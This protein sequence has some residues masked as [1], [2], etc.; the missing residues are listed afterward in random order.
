MK[1]SI[2]AFQ[3]RN[4]TCV[5]RSEMR[6]ILS[7]VGCTLSDLE[8]RALEK[9]IKGPATKDA[10]FAAICRELEGIRKDWVLTLFSNLETIPGRAPK[11][12]VV[13]AFSPEKHPDV[14]AAR[15][16]SEEIRRRFVSAFDMILD[17]KQVDIGQDS[18][19]E[20]FRY[21]SAC[22]DK[23]EYFKLILEN[24]WKV[25]PKQS[26][27][28]K[29]LAPPVIS[30]EKRSPTKP[31]CGTLREALKLGQQLDAAKSHIY[32]SKK[33]VKKAPIFD[34]SLPAGKLTKIRS[35]DGASACLNFQQPTSGSSSRKIAAREA[36]AGIQAIINRLKES[37]SK[38]GVHGII[39]LSRTFKR[40]DEDGSGALNMSEFT[41]AM[42]DADLR[43]TNT[44]IRMLFDYF[45]TNHSG[46]L[47]LEEF[48]NGV[49]EPMTPRR[50]ALVRQA[51]S[52][53]DKD[54][55]GLLEPSDIVE[56]YDASQHPDVLS[57]SKTPDQIFRDFLD[58]FDVD[59]LH[60][61]KITPEEWEHYYNNISG[62]IQD[63]DYFELMMRNAWHISGGEGWCE[64]STNRR[65]LVTHMDGRET[66]EEIKADLHMSPSDMPAI[67]N[68]L[69]LQGIRA[70][71]IKLH[72]AVDTTK[73][74]K[75]KPR[76][77]RES[78][79]A[80][81]CLDHT[82]RLRS[83]NR[84][85]ETKQAASAG[86]QA[87][88]EKL[89]QMLKSRGAHGIIGLARAF[90]LMDDDGNRVLSLGE[91]IKAIRE[92]KLELSDREI[93]LLFEH[94]DTDHNGSIDF[95]EFLAGVRDPMNER[96]LELV[97]RAFRLIDKDNNGLLEPSD[98]VE[99]YDAS[100]HPEVLAGKKSPEQ[101]FREFLDTFDVDHLHTGAITPEEWEHYYQN[102]SSSIDDDD[103]FELMMRNAW[104]ISGGTGWCANTS[105]RRV[106]VT[107]LDGRETV[108]EIKDDIHMT[109][110]DV[111]AIVNHLR[112]Q[113][114]EAK[115]VKLTSAVEENPPKESA[116]ACLSMID[117]APLLRNPRRQQ[118]RA[119]NAG[120]QAILNRLK[121]ELKS[122]GCRG[123]IGLGRTF[124]IMD[125]DGN[126]S[127]SLGEFTRA[128]RHDGLELNDREIRLLFEYFDVDHSRS[129]D[130]N[131]FLVGVRDP[132]NARRLELVRKAFQLMDKDNNGLLE[133]SDIV[134]TY[135]S[136]QHPEVLSGA[137]T[138]EQVFREF[139]D[140][141]DVDGLH[142][143]K[144]TP[145][146]WEH[147][148]ANVSSSIDDDDYFELMMRNAWRISGGTGWCENTANRRVLVT[149]KDGRETIE[150]IKDDLNVKSSDMSAITNHLRLQGV[151]ARE[152][153]LLGSV[154][155]TPARRPTTKRDAF[156]SRGTASCLRQDDNTPQST[157]PR[158]KTKKKANAG[159]QALLNR[160]KQL[161]KARGVHG[162]IGLAR[163]FRMMDEDRNGA[164]N[165]AEFRHA[166]A[167]SQ[168]ELSGRDIQMLF[169]YFDVDH[170]GSIE[171][172]EFLAGVRDPMNPKRLELVRQAFR[173]MDKDNNGL[174][175]PKDIVQ[176]Y[177]ASQHPDVL[178]G[179]KTEEKVFRE[180]LDTFD[181][182]GLHT[183]SITPEEWEHYYNNISS[184]IEDDNYFE[185]VMRNAWHISGGTGAAENSTN[186]RVLVRHRDGRTTVEEIKNDLGVRSN[187]TLSIMNHL[188]LQG[189]EARSIQLYDGQEFDIT[190]CTAGRATRAARATESH[191]VRE[192][193][194]HPGT[195]VDDR[196][197]HVQFASS[198]DPTRLP[199]GPEVVQYVRQA[200][201]HRSLEGLAAIRRN[202]MTAANES[203]TG[204]LTTED[205]RRALADDGVVLRSEIVSNFIKMVG[206]DRKDSATVNQVM[207]TL[208]G[209][210]SPSSSALV[211][212]IYQM[213]LRQSTN[214]TVTPYSLAEAY[215]ANNH[216][217][218]RFE[219]RTAEQVFEEFISSFDLN[220]VDEAEISFAEF[221]DFCRSLKACTGDEEYFCTIL[222]SVFHA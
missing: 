42:R 206:R 124:R 213:L 186:R 51:F 99:A 152:V 116:A 196:R 194:Q 120:I 66:V 129:I 49:R 169:E 6:H 197:R 105:N 179:H 211:H 40:M 88:I 16:K 208:N 200:V 102:I 126:R 220:S 172:N 163:Q 212:K 31:H 37:L 20:Y 204:F 154:D 8:S 221:E 164:L 79:G 109:N 118:D 22:V 15:V 28:A 207:Q 176:A 130:F 89:K 21:L 128:L 65:V 1:N 181:V 125:E 167:Q 215:D 90:R 180:F 77:L 41:R 173:L 75:P 82:L 83:S 139:L 11:A 112:L 147:Y 25:E 19:L 111:S 202:L 108:E 183:G 145:E 35:S 119:P 87:V 3:L 177:D 159:I 127:L 38:R 62:S 47:D 193:L 218:V 29:F 86:L 84:R 122:R 92:C 160:L 141:F 39:G 110:G 148:Y 27:K 187:D 61:G 93:R 133:V 23:D 81:S 131:E 4:T 222:R 17:P 53:I 96:R 44:E 219:G 98:I 117:G 63:D 170:S 91:F 214:R 104:H 68:H 135:D 165:Y 161:L 143:G 74:A 140:T 59:G 12:K 188:R 7:T 155:D 151:E 136:S 58:T 158:R 64:N 36:N 78:G 191:L 146:E 132:M 171:F 2:D 43:L 101:V 26:M 203:N 150:E 54:N 71:H 190:E 166:M 24:T 144:I 10:F 80:A 69:R 52:L 205:V 48:L 149:H 33:K 67:M 5:S 45:D 153:T 70:K 18:W 50:L 72:D 142:T 95:N 156:G 76:N 123:I 9:I 113:G 192:L 174:L 195:T 201:Q 178:S 137:K 199:T 209:M 103:Y 60:T 13:K 107:H 175:E 138:E 94:F 134:E 73:D 34:H 46:S 157:L 56:A 216:P 32:A 189:I 162:L 114:I 210:L 182:D 217:D 184:S 198:S 100:Q 30:E 168:L 106:L 14:M 115:D 85:K 57:G 185:L 97:R 55:N 121:L